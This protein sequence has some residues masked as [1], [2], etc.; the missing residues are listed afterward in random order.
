MAQLHAEF[1]GISITLELEVEASP[2]EQGTP[3]G[4]MDESSDSNTDEGEDDDIIPGCGVL[5]FDSPLIPYDSIWI[6]VSVFMAINILLT[7]LV[8]RI[9]PNLRFP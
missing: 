4:R 8:G 6:R 9:N 2:V 5:H 7:N 3:S 1:W